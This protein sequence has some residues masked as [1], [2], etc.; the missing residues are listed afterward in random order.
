M[1]SPSTFPNDGKC[2]GGTLSQDG[3]RAVLR[4]S[5]WAR[6]PPAFQ[7]RWDLLQG[8]ASRN[9]TQKIYPSLSFISLVSL[10]PWYF[11]LWNYNVLSVFCL[12]HRDLKGPQGQKI[13]GGLPPLQSRTFLTKTSVPPAFGS[14]FS[15]KNFRIQCGSVTGGFDA[16]PFTPRVWDNLPE[17]PPQKNGFMLPPPP[18]NSI[19]KMLV[20]LQN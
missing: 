8:T 14:I 16:S 10:F 17:G 15:K 6:R 11:L 12:V 4:T 13:S 19:E 7:Q 3:K 1:V 9:C 2:F 20:F 18:T 5:G